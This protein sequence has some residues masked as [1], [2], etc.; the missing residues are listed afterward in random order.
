[1]LYNEEH[2]SLISTVNNFAV[3]E[4]HPF[5]EEWEK[6]GMFPAH[7]IFK[8]FGSIDLLGITKK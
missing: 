1:M 5:I 8:K 2:L 4:I 6:T 3:N 7:T